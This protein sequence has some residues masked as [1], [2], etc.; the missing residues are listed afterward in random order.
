[1]VVLRLDHFYC[2]SVVSL[3]SVP[4][5]GFLLLEVAASATDPDGNELEINADALTP[6]CC[7]IFSTSSSVNGL[8]LPNLRL[9]VVTGIPVS[10]EAWSMLSRLTPRPARTLAIASLL[11]LSLF[12][13]TI[14]SS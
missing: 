14:Y 13:G 7:A 3:P 5:E 6:K 9:S 2:L 4:A 10:A 12:T 1:M 8:A 11:R